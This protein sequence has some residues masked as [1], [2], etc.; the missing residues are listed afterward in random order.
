MTPATRHSS[1]EVYEIKSVTT[2]PIAAA[3]QL[4]YY[5]ILLNGLDPKKRTWAAGDAYAPPPVIAVGRGAFAFVFK[6]SPGVI[7]YQVIDAKEVMA[8]SAGY[9]ASSISIDVT[10]YTLKASLGFAL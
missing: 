10:A 2:G 3:A 4:N 5:L 7:L 9:L 1:G 6:P 8:Y